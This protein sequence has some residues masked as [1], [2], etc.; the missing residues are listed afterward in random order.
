MFCI[1]GHNVSQ[2]ARDF[3]RGPGLQARIVEDGVEAWQALR[4]NHSRA[5]RF[6]TLPCSVFAMALDAIA[7]TL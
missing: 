5:A 4:K 2:G 6:A 3:L 1:P 7:D